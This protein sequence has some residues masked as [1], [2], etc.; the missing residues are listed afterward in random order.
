M[1]RRLFFKFGM[2][3]GLI[4]LLLIPLRMIHGLV[5][6]RAS[7]R[8]EARHSVQNSWTGEQKVIGPILVVP[9]VEHTERKVWDDQRKEYR[10]S[11][12][13]ESHQLLVAPA[14]LE[15]EGK[16][17][18]EER[19]RG[20]YAI[21]VYTAALS[22][23]GSFN[24]QAMVDAVAANGASV[25]WGKPFLTV[26]VSDLRGITSQ[27]TI[28]WDGEKLAFAS[29]PGIEGAMSGMHAG[30]PDLDSS[31]AQ[32]HAFEMDLLVRGMEQIAFA[33]LGRDTR[34]SLNSPWPHPSFIGRFLPVDHNVTDAGFSAHWLASSFS[35]DINT[36]L[37]D[38][39]LGKCSLLVNNTF[40]VSLI[41]SV[42]IY[43]QA[44]RSIKYGV[45]FLSLT[46]TLFFLYEVTKQL[47]VHPVQYLLVGLALS[48]FFL[49]LVSLSER[50]PFG[51]A[52]SVAA[53]A[54][55][56]VLAGY[57]SGVLR[58]AKSGAMFA[59]LLGV[60][61]A[62]LYMIIRSEDNALLMGSLLLFLVLSVV[63]MATRHM[64]WYAVSE[65]LA[66]QLPRRKASDVG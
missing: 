8:E 4:L 42:D 22:L 25:T 58:S 9:F 35:G 66:A 50:L 18:T 19:K 27:P 55:S 13:R 51:V 48:I 41:Q 31:A 26:L 16:V 7:Y 17:E 5:Q 62:T 43:L 20:L 59:G 15:I 29:G 57:V 52:Y 12:F 63:M 23:R 64:D 11:Q 32:D 10:V 1:Q 30:L 56:L 44:E 33:P 47:A 39:A 37:V 28:N 45:L 53:A 46:F 6:D 60:L 65:R 21:P 49:L 40:G 2:I 38:C 36:A 14:S 24:T 61:Y 54:C 3:G 34:V